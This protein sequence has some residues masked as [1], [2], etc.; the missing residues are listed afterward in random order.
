MDLSI[1]SHDPSCEGGT[2][3]FQDYFPG[4]AGNTSGDAAALEITARAHLLYD[5]EQSLKVR[6]HHWYSLD[7]FKD[8]FKGT[9]TVNYCL[10]KTIFFCR[11][12]LDPV[13][14]A[15]LLG[16]WGI[17]AAKEALAVCSSGDVT[18]RAQLLRH[19]CQLCQPL[20]CLV[21]FLRVSCSWLKFEAISSWFEP[22]CHFSS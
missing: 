19:S 12:S 21:I 4:Q 11:F 10:W 2:S 7:G 16:T 18:A 8:P 13:L 22:T 9:F 1:P 5:P 14:P 17:Q 20:R 6:C 3:G 15:T